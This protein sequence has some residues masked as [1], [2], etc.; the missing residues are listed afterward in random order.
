MLACIVSTA[1]LLCSDLFMLV[2]V[3]YSTFIAELIRVMCTTEQMSTELK[4]CRY[5]WCLT[6]TSAV[7]FYM[8]LN[9]SN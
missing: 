6:G 2:C 7:A 1:D 4:T 5:M 8:P 9:H 3:H